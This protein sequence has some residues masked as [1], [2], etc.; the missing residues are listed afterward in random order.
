MHSSVKMASPPHCAPH[1]VS[2][3]SRPPCVAP[4]RDPETKHVATGEESIDSLREGERKVGKAQAACHPRN[5]NVHL[6]H[7]TISSLIHYTG[8]PKRIR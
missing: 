5:A 2:H 8:G 4:Q 7:L 1:L 3:S 6:H